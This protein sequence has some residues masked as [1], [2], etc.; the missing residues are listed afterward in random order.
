LLCVA[1]KISNILFKRL[2]PY[3]EKTIG[4]YQCGYLG[5]QS[6]VNQIFTV[7]QILKKCE[8]GKDR[9]HLFIDFKA[10]CDSIDRRSLYAAMEEMNIPKT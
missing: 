7:R 5:E 10:A 8:H 2:L 4:D 3:V 9:H 1:Y 6:T